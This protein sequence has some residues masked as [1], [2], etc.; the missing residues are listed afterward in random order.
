MEVP[1]SFKE[2]PAYLYALGVVN[3][4]F[5]AN[6][7]ITKVAKDFLEELE[8]DN[9]KYYFDYDLVDY[10]DELLGFLIVPSGI[11]ID[12]PVNKMLAGFQWFFILN[13]LAWK[14]AD[15]H[16]KRRYE[17]SILLIARKSGKTFITAIIFIILMLLEPKNSNFFSVAPTLDLST[18]IFDEATKIIANSPILTSRFRVTK[19][20]IECKFNNNKF[21]PLATGKQTMDGR[22]ASVFLVDEAGALR[23]SYPINAMESSQIN[24][25]NRTGILISTAY[26]TLSNPMTEQVKLVEDII[27]GKK[28]IDNIFGLIYKPDFPNEWKTNDDEMLK[29]NPLAVGNSE[30]F[31]FLVK[32]RES[33]IDMESERGN[34]MTKHM[35]IF[36]NGGIVDTYVTEEDMLG[37]EVPEG[38]IEWEGK[39]VFLGLDLSQSNDNTAVAMTHHDK[40]ADIL[41]AKTWI[42][43]PS[44]RE[45]DKTKAEGISYEKA[46]ELGIAIPSGGMSIDYDQVEEFIF[47]IEK[48]YGVNV[49]GIGYD[50]YSAPAMATRLSKEY[51]LAEINQRDA[52]TFLAAKFLREKIQDN[53]FHYEEN[54]MLTA[55]FLNAK[56]KTSEQMTYHLNKKESS[57]KIDAV[58]A[59][60]DSVALW[61]DDLTM[62][63]EGQPVTFV[64]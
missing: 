3:E 18:L 15:D 27:D 30:L 24:I 52:G 56:M 50:R 9:S 36:I 12:K 33:A 43:Y 19:T 44:M 10:I 35:N 41:L 13:A 49:I 46:A 17:K 47:D 54:F 1:E 23:D 31:D 32:K 51:D 63:A 16:E 42:F 20:Y 48:N 55:N 22:L 40:D 39:D 29:A 34:F 62:D 37:V 11:A 4:E 2:H 45:A 21:T 38:T 5:P 7:Y 14:M 61:L 60:V 59:I 53:E 57:G 26:P 6:V 64:I 58:A 25:K 28:D 8:N